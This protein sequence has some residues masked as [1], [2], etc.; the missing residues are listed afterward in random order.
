MPRATYQ[1]PFENKVW[2][3]LVRLAFQLTGNSGEGYGFKAILNSEG[4]LLAVFSQ[5][6]YPDFKHRGEDAEATL[7]YDPFDEPVY[8]FI[9]W[10]NVSADSLERILNIE[11]S[12]EDL[13]SFNGDRMDKIP[14]S[15]N[16]MF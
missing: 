9:S 11:F 1:Y 7:F 3:G 5:R 13:V 4:S 2:D 8:Q 10:S 14:S 12:P 16:V 6:E 15:H